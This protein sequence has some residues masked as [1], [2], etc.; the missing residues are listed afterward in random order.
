MPLCSPGPSLA[1]TNWVW[2]QVIWSQS[3]NLKRPGDKDND[4]VSEKENK[5]LA[6]Y[7][8]F[9]SFPHTILTLIILILISA[10]FYPVIPASQC[11]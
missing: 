1:D 5:F 2:G 7:S 8:I 6:V 3:T 4:G 9:S 10:D 11:T